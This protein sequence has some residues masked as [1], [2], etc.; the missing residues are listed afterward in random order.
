MPV[1]TCRLGLKSNL[2]TDL[3][4]FNDDIINCEFVAALFLFFSF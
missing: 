1:K 2:S 4:F 3:I